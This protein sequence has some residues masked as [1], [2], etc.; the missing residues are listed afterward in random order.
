MAEV[1]WPARYDPANTKVFVS[2]QLVIPASPVVVWAWLIRAVRWPEWYPNASAVRLPGDAADLAPAM[3]FRWK[4]FGINLVSNVL[5]FEPGSRIAWD[6]HAAG[7]DVYH[8][9]V[10]EPR[11]PDEVLV[12]TEETQNG[13]LARLS[14]AVMPNR[15]SR[16]H[17]IW[18]ERLREQ[19]QSGLP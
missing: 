15:M 8:A 6:G 4:T 17:Q 7:L 19:A 13:W 18:L 16:Y 1:R 2:N 14:N 5:E 11:G 3:Q 9:W 10:I 12:L